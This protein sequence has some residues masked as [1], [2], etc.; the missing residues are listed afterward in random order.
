MQS[1]L[2]LG[3][4]WFPFVIFGLIV[5]SAVLGSFFT[6]ET[7]RSVI[8]TRFGSSCESQTPV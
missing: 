7:A 4:L 3:W 2:N 6:V 8:V 5:L 1:T